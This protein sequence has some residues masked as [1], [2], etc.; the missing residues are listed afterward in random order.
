M[1]LPDKNFCKG[2]GL[3]GKTN[4]KIRSPNSAKKALNLPARPKPTRKM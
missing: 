1:R 4:S 3:G 2:F